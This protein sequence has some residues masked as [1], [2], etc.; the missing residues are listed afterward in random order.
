M[1]IFSERDIRF[2][3]QAKEVTIIKKQK[4]K[5][6]RR[7]LRRIKINKERKKERMRDAGRGLGE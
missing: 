6:L 1:F 3:Q 5:R 7:S 2:A 4:F